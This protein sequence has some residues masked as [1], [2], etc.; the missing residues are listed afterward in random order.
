MKERRQIKDLVAPM[1]EVSPGGAIPYAVA[2]HKQNEAI[3]GAYS[4]GVTTG[5]RGQFERAAEMQDHGLAKGRRGV[6]NPGCL[7][8]AV[9]RIGLDEI[10]SLD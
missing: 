10:L 5:D 8:F 6:G 1:R 7:P 3:V 4:D 9:R 2:V